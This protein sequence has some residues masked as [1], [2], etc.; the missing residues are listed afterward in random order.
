MQ[1][2]LDWIVN[3]PWLSALGSIAS[4]VSLCVMVRKKRPHQIIQSV[5]AGGSIRRSPVTS[6]GSEITD[7]QVT[8]EKDIV[9]SAVT[10][11][12]DHSD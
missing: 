5:H 8:A 2:I 12:S 3:H 10:Q 7:Q 4:I 11:S 1:P 9:D 6:T